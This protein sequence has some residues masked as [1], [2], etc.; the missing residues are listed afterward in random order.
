MDILLAINIVGWLGSAA[1]V[2]AYALI[3]TQRIKGDSLWYQLLNLIGSLFLVV[4]T[5]YL[6]AF[7]SAFVNTIWIGIA[8]FALW[9]IAKKDS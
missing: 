9:R 5:F 7:P 3:S 6:G 8:L 1:V 2:S 4:N